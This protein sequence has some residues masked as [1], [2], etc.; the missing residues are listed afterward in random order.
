M[1]YRSPVSTPSVRLPVQ[2][3]S[4]TSRA[5]QPRSRRPS[6][7]F[8]AGNASTCTSSMNTEDIRPIR[9]I[10]STVRSKRNSSQNVEQAT[11][12]NFPTDWACCGL[13]GGTFS[14]TYPP[15]GLPAV[16]PAWEA[17]WDRHCYSTR[18]CKR[19]PNL[20][21]VVTK[22]VIPLVIPP[23]TTR[24]DQAVSTGRPTRPDQR[25]RNPARRRGR[26]WVDF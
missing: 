8:L 19:K 23:R 6:P 11:I 9:P 7:R 3:A 1:G 5:T 22:V 16:S 26:S 15:V 20:E 12:S 17:G 4:H 24:H 18:T 2:R 21:S 14:L 13:V 10:R 25:G